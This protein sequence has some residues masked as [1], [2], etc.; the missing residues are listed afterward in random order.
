MASS[1]LRLPVSTA[2]REYHL[3]LVP[4]PSSRP[5]LGFEC[6]SGSVSVLVEV[7]QHT[8][9][10][11]LH[12][13]SAKLHIDSCTFSAAR[14]VSWHCDAA[15][16][17]LRVQLETELAPGTFGKLVIAYSGQITT[18]SVGI[19]QNS[20][21]SGKRKGIGTQ[22]EMMDARRVFP[23]WDEPQ[24]KA[25]FSLVITVPSFYTVLFNTDVVSTSSLHNGELTRHEFAATPLMSSYL[26]A[27]F[28]GEVESLQA[29]SKNGVLVRVWREVGRV[30]VGET[31]LDYA[32]RSLDFLEDFYG[33]HYPMKKLDHIGLES[34]VNGGMEN[35][36]LVVYSASSFYVSEDNSFASVLHMIVMIAHETAHMWFGN[37]V[38]M[39]WW[40]DLWLNEGFAT[41]AGWLAVRHLKP[42]WDIASLMF[43]DDLADAFNDDSVKNTHAVEVKGRLQGGFFFFFFFFLI[44][45]FFCFN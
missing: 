14:V 7:I 19:Y 36:G 15:V 27:L 21:A 17:Q 10:L 41:Y 28:V 40:N 1:S 11:V 12:A 29:V 34:F 32:V 44:F 25:T 22:L 9:V 31:Q 8:S 38:T 35:W 23:C 20:Y 4:T 45:F 6:F 16:D 3:E 33:F 24:F 13:S 2:P 37:L 18:D 42:A 30:G 5:E 43:V 26:V 39:R